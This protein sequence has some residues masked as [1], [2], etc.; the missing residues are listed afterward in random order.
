MQPNW[1]RRRAV[2]YTPLSDMGS[3]IYNDAK[4]NFDFFTFSYE[5][6]DIDISK[7]GGANIAQHFKFKSEFWGESFLKLCNLINN[8]YDVVLFMNS[9]LYVSISELNKFFDINDLFMLDFSQPSLSFNSYYSHVHT[10]NIPGA[11][12]VEVPFIEIMMPC[13]STVV[14]NEICRIGLTTISGWGIDNLL[15]PYIKDK[16]NLKNPAVIHDCSVLHVKPVESS[17][18]YSDGLTAIEQMNKLR[19]H[20]ILNAP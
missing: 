20:L 12:V 14:I 15:F 9:D 5:D 3:L 13:L 16:L 6:S 2:I 17:R 19:E 4:A 7:M 18:Q 10:M 11:G 1:R 8:R